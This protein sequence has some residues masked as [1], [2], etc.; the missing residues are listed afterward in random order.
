MIPTQDMIWVFI[1]YLW[2]VV[3]A[4]ANWRFAMVRVPDFGNW[5]EKKNLCLFLGVGVSSLKVTLSLVGRSL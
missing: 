5:W 1:V 3:T 4:S 2:R